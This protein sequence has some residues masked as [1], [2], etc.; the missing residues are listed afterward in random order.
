L[1]A[2]NLIPAKASLAES[3]PQSRYLSMRDQRLVF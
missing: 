3:D 2:T 1:A